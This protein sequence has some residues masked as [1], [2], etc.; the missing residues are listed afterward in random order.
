M[1]R[2]YIKKKTP[3]ELYDLKVHAKKSVT[4]GGKKEDIYLLRSAQLLHSSPLVFCQYKCNFMLHAYK[5]I[6]RSFSTVIHFPFQITRRNQSNSHLMDL[7]HSWLQYTFPPVKPA[8]Q[9]AIEIYVFVYSSYSS[10]K[11]TQSQK[12]KNQLDLKMSFAK[13]I[14]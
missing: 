11:P 10:T 2:S 13:T 8:N 12:L 5:M 3:T 1:L 14:S 9:N 6:S 7:F 4:N